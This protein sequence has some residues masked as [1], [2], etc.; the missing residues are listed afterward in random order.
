MGTLGA[1]TPLDI[2]Q[3][4]SRTERSSINHAVTVLIGSGLLLAGPPRRFP[5]SL[6]AESL[7]GTLS[8]DN[9]AAAHAAAAHALY[10]SQADSE[11]L[12]RHIAASSGTEE[13]WRID[14]LRVG[15]RGASE[16]GEVT[17]A[18][19]LLRHALGEASSQDTRQQL[20]VELGTTEAATDTAACV[21]HLGEAEQLIRDSAARAGFV[22][23]LAQALVQLQQPQRALALLDRAVAETPDNEPLLTRILS[24]RALLTDAGAPESLDLP[25]GHEHDSD[26]ASRTPEK[27]ALLAALAVRSTVAPGGADRAALLAGEALQGAIAETDLTAINAVAALLT[28]DRLEA[29]RCWS[30]GLRESSVDGQPPAVRAAVAALRARILHRTGQLPQARQQME[31][32]LSLA[33]ETHPYWGSSTACVGAL[34]WADTRN[35][36]SPAYGSWSLR[37]RSTCRKTACLRTGYGRSC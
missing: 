23:L 25:F 15:A 22:P 14:A 28:A 24:G 3:A 20:L 30:G 10:E 32:A 31:Y 7:A 33:D 36:P 19:R 16:R 1:D 13:P 11:R 2:L 9:Q 4:A 37:S 21:R 34:S 5:H 17:A 12:S 27:S 8:A 6:V 26:A 35:T 18:T 29:A